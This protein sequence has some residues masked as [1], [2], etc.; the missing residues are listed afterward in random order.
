MTFT[1][2]YHDG[3]TFVSE[4]AALILDAKYEWTTRNSTA[5]IELEL[6]LKELQTAW[7]SEIPPAKSVIP[8]TRMLA[9][10]TY[11]DLQIKTIRVS[12]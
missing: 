1:V 6:S 3:A 7:P 4:A 8:L 5:F 9:L 11:I 10:V 12:A 2:E